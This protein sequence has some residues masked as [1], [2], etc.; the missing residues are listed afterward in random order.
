LCMW[1]RLCKNCY[2]HSNKS[3]RKSFRF[4]WSW[5]PNALPGMTWKLS[6]IL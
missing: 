2:K 4:M 5:V 6:I 1:V 3:R